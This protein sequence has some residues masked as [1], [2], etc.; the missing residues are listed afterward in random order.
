MIEINNVIKKFSQVTALNGVSFQVRKGEV[1]GFLGPNGAGKTT[2]MKLITSFYEPTAG[3]IV[4]DGLDV[5]KHSL[6]TRRQIGYLPE[7]V[8]LYDDMK[9]YEYLRFICEIRDIDHGKILPRLREVIDQCGLQ[10]VIG[11]NIDEL[12]KGYRQRVGLAQAIMHDPAILI[13]DEPTAGLDPNQIIE[14][15]S[16]IKNIGREKTVLFSTHI[17]AEAQSTCDRVVIINKGRIVGEGRPDDLTAQFSGRA[18]FHVK[19]RVDQA[20]LVGALQDV[21]G[22]SEIK[23]INEEGGVGVYQIAINNE[24]AQEVIAAAICQQGWPLLEFYELQTSLEDVFR[25]LTK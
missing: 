2:T 17:L 21:T 23:K 1:L 15:R 10:K 8:P 18:N 22:L 12:S 16:L 11:K 14:I 24:R 25:E 20:A 19:L 9:V 7:T 6:Q 13:L 4:I 3:S 5:V